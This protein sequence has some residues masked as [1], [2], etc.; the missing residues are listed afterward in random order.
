[1]KRLTTNIKPARGYSHLLHI[2]L[3]ILLPV[4][5]YIL[6]RTDFMSLAI[7]LVL[8][9][10]WRMFAVRHRYW[11]LNILS[12]AVDMIVGVSLVLF[13]ANTSVV[14]WQLFWTASYAVWLVYLKPRSDTLSVSAQAMIAQLLGLS[15]LYIRFGGLPLVLLVLCT[16]GITYAA[17]RHF[18]ASF[19]E[20]HTTM[21]AHIWA[22]FSASLAFILGHWLLFYGQVAQLVLILTVVG[23]TVAALYY[24]HSTSRIT[25]TIQRYLLVIM[26]LILLVVIVFSNWHAKII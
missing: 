25:G 18:F 23:Y 1:M 3:N 17:A 11:L 20:V 15:A 8:L 9:S 5:V 6:V 13:I 19:D 12:N 14:W 10:K 21:F 26:S 4:A 22:Y 2:A 16:W 7:V 24:L